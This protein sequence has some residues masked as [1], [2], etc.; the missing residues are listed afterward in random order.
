MIMDPVTLAADALI[1]EAK[2]LMAEYRIGGIPVV[3]GEK[4]LIGIITNRDLRFETEDHKPVGEVMTAQP[5]VTADERTTMDE[6]EGILQ[7]N[8]IEKFP[9]SAKTA[10]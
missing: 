6:A 10:P 2:K 4:K 8:K 9:S 3:D 1:G 5:L 7:A